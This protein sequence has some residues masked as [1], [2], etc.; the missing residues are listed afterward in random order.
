MIACNPVVYFEQSTLGVALFGP[1]FHLTPSHCLRT[2]A[3]E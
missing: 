2:M 3:F 1:F